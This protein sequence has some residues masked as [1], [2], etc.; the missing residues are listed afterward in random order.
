[1]EIEDQY[2]IVFLMKAK[3]SMES[4]PLRLQTNEYKKIL[5][6]INQYIGINCKHHIISDS[7][8]ISCDES[9][10]IKYCDLCYKTF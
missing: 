4:L 3:A 2:D 5:E 6:L 10:P 1:M 7:I 8:D 9:M